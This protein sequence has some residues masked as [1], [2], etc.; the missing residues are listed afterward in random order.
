MCLEKL[1]FCLTLGFIIKNLLC[2]FSLLPR[3]NL[4]PLK[5]NEVTKAICS[6]VVCAQPSKHH[7]K[8]VYLKCQDYM[9]NLGTILINSNINKINKLNCNT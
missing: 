3:E 2:L 5:T 7:M 6:Q 4:L 8:D 1:F 9:I